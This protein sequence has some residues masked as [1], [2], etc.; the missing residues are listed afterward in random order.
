MNFDLDTIKQG[1]AALGMAL[2]A[3]KQVKEL[4]PT[5]PKNEE[6]FN[7]AIEQIE[8]AERQFKNAEAQAAQA[9]GYILCRNH[10]PPGIMLS[11]DNTNWKCPVCGNELKPKP[12]PPRPWNSLG[13]KR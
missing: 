12:I 5:V 3:I 10:F 1:L 2:N 4:V 6:L 11:S 9:M 7:K 13:R 8:N